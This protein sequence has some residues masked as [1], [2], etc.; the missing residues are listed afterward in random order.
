[1]EDGVEENNLNELFVQETLDPRIESVMPILNRIHKKV[2]ESIVDKEMNKLAEWADSLSEAEGES[3]T[4]NNPVGIPEEELE[5][6]E[7]EES[8]LQ[9]YLGDKK[10][11]EKGM[12]ALRKAGREHAGK[13]KMQSIRAKFSDKEDAN[14]NFINTDVQAVT[15]EDDMNVDPIES[16]T[17]RIHDKISSMLKKLSKPDSNQELD[18]AAQPWEDE[19]KED[20]EDDTKPKDTKG[21]DGSEH[22]GHSRAKHLAKSAI[23]KDEKEE[24]KEGQEELAR[25]LTIMNHRR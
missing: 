12:D 11:G 19:D 5:E 14:E 24:V 25:I 16:G 2:S 20:K 21:K 17:D 10:Y 4:S 23:P 13:E 7:V 8:A 6:S 15:T 9:A 22:G 3:L 1:M 18:E